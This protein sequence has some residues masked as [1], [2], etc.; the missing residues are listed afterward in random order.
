MR[1]A[2]SYDDQGNILTLFDPKALQSDQ[3][4]LKYVPADQENHD[5]LDVPAEHE[6][7]TFAELADALRV[8]AERGAPRFT[9]KR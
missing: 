3:G 1:L 7:K 6:A 4:W 8:E 9:A 2:V 5:I